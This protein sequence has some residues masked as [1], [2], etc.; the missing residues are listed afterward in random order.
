MKDV[1]REKVKQVP[2]VRQT[3]LDSGDREIAEA[4]PFDNFWSLGLPKETASKTDPNHWPGSNILGRLWLE[5]REELRKQ[6]DDGYI[7]KESRKD[8]R[9]LKEISSERRLYL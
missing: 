3:L 4:V 9:N 1:L 6:I 7:M 5:I 2:E 8:K